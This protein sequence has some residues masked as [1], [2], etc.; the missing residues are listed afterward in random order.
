MGLFFAVLATQAAE[1][2]QAMTSADRFPSLSPHQ[3]FHYVIIILNA[4]IHIVGISPSI[5]EGT[6]S[7]LLFQSHGLTLDLYG[8]QW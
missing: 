4:I 7:L 1:G 8:S 3:T 2:S 5:P 6:A